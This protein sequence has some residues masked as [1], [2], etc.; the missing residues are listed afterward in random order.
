ME[1]F[2]AVT[3]VSEVAKPG[4]VRDGVAASGEEKAHHPGT[5]DRG[6]LLSTPVALP[7]RV[8]HDLAL[9]LS[10]RSTLPLDHSDA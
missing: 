10:V 7:A 3:G 8:K 5:R 1:V 9:R 4:R 6:T 2:G